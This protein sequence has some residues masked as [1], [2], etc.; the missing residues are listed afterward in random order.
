MGEEIVEGERKNGGG[1][2]GA[3]YPTGNE[4]ER[5]RVDDDK[6]NGGKASCRVEF[7]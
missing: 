5:E 1:E 6:G 7:A 3:S 2:S 4:R